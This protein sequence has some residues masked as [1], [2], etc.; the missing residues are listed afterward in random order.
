MINMGFWESGA[1]KTSFGQPLGA[2]CQIGYVVED[3]EEAVVRF[4]RLMG[5]GPWLLID[6]FQVREQSY[7]G[8]P[9]DLRLSIAAAYRG[10]TMIEL[11]MQKNDVSSVYMDVVR[12]R[13][14]GI[15]HYAVVVEDLDREEARLKEMGIDMPFYATTTEIMG[16]MRV[17]Y[18]D[19][20]HYIN[21][22]LEM[23][24]FNPVMDQFFAQM[25][26]LADNWDGKDLIIRA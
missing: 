25:K 7:R 19:T 18:S 13:G 3:V 26:G 24:E 1:I 23:C 10:N 21:A 5:I 14:Y 8:K 11:I 15:H 12:E 4:N 22:M 16:D 17:I 20:R 2:V 9:T 6:D